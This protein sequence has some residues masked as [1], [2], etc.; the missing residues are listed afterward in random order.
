MKKQLLLFSVLAGMLFSLMSCE[1]FI[2][3]QVKVQ[4]DSASNVSFILAGKTYDILPGESYVVSDL[5][6]GT[7]QYTTIYT[8]PSGITSSNTDG[9]VAGEMVFH[10][11]TEFLLVYTSVTEGE[12][13]TL[14]GTL[15]SS[16]K[17]GRTDMEF[18]PNF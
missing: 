5:N 12:S 10:A 18:E 3:N 9:D 11:G 13:Y 4:N 2:E 6:K 16:D 8:I 15:S 1:P 7:F 14:F 17:A